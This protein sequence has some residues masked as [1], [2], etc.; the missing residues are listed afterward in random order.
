MVD[1][2]HDTRTMLVNGGYLSDM[3]GRNLRHID[4][5][6]FMQRLKED[7]QHNDRF[8]Y[9]PIITCNGNWQSEY[10]YLFI[11]NLTFGHSHLQLKTPTLSSSHC[12]AHPLRILWSLSHLKIFSSLIQIVFLKTSFISPSKLSII[13]MINKNKMVILNLIY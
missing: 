12:K 11:F 6:L 4:D 8:V 5:R 13:R 10:T 2:V 7:Q 9:K 1:T 3:A